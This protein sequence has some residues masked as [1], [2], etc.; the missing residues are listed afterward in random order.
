MKSNKVTKLLTALFLGGTLM[1]GLS[2][3]AAAEPAKYDA[4]KIDPKLVVTDLKLAA[5]PENDNYLILSWSN[6]LGWDSDTDTDLELYYD[7]SNNPGFDDS[8]KD[9]WANNN[10]GTYGK[11]E[12][13]YVGESVQYVRAFLRQEKDGNVT[14]GPYSEVLTYARRSS[15]SQHPGTA[16]KRYDAALGVPNIAVNTTKD[17]DVEVTWTDKLVTPQKDDEDL[18][19]VIEYSQDPSFQDRESTGV[20][21]VDPTDGTYDSNAGAYKEPKPSAEIGVGGGTNYVRAYFMRDEKYGPVS[22]T[23]S[24]TKKV[25]KPEL[26]ETTVNASS[27]YF[28]LADEGEVTGYEIQRENNKGKWKT[29]TKTTNHIFTDKG[30]AKNTEYTYRIRSYVYNRYDQKITNS[31]WIYTGAVTW[32]RSDSLELRVMPTSSPTKAKLT[33]NKVA[34]ATEYKI[35]RAVGL[36]NSETLSKGT[37][38]GIRSWKLIKTLKTKKQLKQKSYTDTK[39]KAGASYTYKIVAFKELKK[40]KKSKKVMATYKLQSCDDVTLAFD[41]NSMQEISR[42]ENVAGAVTLTWKRVTGAAGYT[43]E[44]YVRNETTGESDWQKVTDRTIAQTSYT[45]APDPAKTDEKGNVTYPEAEYRVYAYNNAQKKSN[46]LYVDVENYERKNTLSKPDGITATAVE[47]NTAVEIRWKKVD[48]A[49]YYVVYRSRRL[50]SYNKDKNLYD[51]DGGNHVYVTEQTAL[52]RTDKITGT[53]A[54]GYISV[55]D[56]HDERELSS[57][58]YLVNEGPQQGVYYYYYVQ[59]FA[60]NGKPIDDEDYDESYYS[61]YFAKPAG[62]ILNAATAAKPTGVKAKSGKRGQVTVSWKA[63]AGANGY[64]VYYSTKKGGEYQLA[65]V[66]SANA[67]KLTVKGLTSK[68]KYYFKVAATTTGAA[69]AIVSSQ[70]SGAASVKVK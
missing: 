44:K 9:N 42:V 4:G 8:Q 20:E 52:R 53:E 62:V 24:V 67:T 33:W 51:Y 2:M 1:T 25:E 17:D 29:L 21:R 30:L 56:R 10:Y 49:A 27:V 16:S 47:N 18:I 50:G 13:L 68:K 69:G 57:G 40:S 36:N 46:A 14:Y 45:F 54:N 11:E 7:Y 19:L 3:T 55:I 32:G 26:E 31:E 35:Y 48:K 63:V 15:A 64:Q 37:V 59:A 58:T 39:L 22:A 66:A 41:D 38:S 70:Q 34:D 5:D 6:K 23:L 12:E 28:N 61:S 60:P 43:V 65:D